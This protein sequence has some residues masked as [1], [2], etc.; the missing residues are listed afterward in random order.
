[1]TNRDICTDTTWK[2]PDQNVKKK[3]FE[4]IE[5]REASRNLHDHVLKI[6]R[7]KYKKIY[8]QK[9]SFIFRPGP[10]QADIV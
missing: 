6:P 7:P 1:M 9:N 10:F 5:S 4:K 2:Y 8:S 3:L